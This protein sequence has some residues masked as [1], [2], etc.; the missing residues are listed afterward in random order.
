MIKKLFGLLLM[1][2]AGF[3]A[4]KI[5]RRQRA[6]PADLD[7]TDGASSV[8][9][10]ESVESTGLGGMA[11]AVNAGTTISSALSG[12]TIVSEALR[13]HELFRS[14]FTE[15]QETAPEAR[16]RRFRE[17]INALVRHEVAE[18]EVVYPLIRTLADGERLA[19]QRVGEEAAAEEL[20]KEMEQEEASTDDFA[21]NLNRLQQMVL[22]HADAEEATVFARIRTEVD[23]QKQRW[24]GAAF[25]AAKKAAPS[26]PHPNA[27]NSA[28][29]NLTAGP[30]LATIDRIRDA[31][32]EA[33]DRMRERQPS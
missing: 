3:A 27:P 7:L 21:R 31:A 25:V 16:E 12:D 26:H 22:R 23:E 2:C 4:W 17:L 18:E 9:A 28:V 24:A 5:V 20:L 6:A 11:A 19:D 32:R 33:V 10:A 8:E 30:I 14:M 15:L 1:A 29:A 13:D